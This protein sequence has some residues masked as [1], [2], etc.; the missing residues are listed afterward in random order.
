MY[1]PLAQTNF[2][3]QPMSVKQAEGLEAVF[4]CLYPGE[5]A[6]DWSVNGTILS[7][8][9][10]NIA[11]DI[12][13]IPSVGGSRAS[14]TILARPEYNNTVVQCEAIVRVNG[15]PDLVLSDIAH[16]TVQGKQMPTPGK[17]CLHL[18]FLN[19]L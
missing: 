10:P 18:R 8:L 15:T 14:L 16:L 2:A 9:S 5:T 6:Y 13:S 4:E 1:T 7:S 12:V 11:S 17:T 3:V 19:H